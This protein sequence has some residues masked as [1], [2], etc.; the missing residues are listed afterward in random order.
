MVGVTSLNRYALWLVALRQNSLGAGL[1][2]QLE[3]A[4]CCTRAVRSGSSRGFPERAAL[5]GG[6]GLE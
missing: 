2:S 4:D 3:M 5:F 1:K 6:M